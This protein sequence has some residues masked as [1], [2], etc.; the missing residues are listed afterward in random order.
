MPPKAK[1]AQPSKKTVEKKKEKVIEDKTFGLKNKK[2]AK[3]QKFI[4]QVQHQV[5]N[6]GAAKKNDELKKQEKEKKLK[7]QK[8]MN[9]LFKPVSTQKVEKGIDPKS[10]LCAFFKQGQCTKGDKCKFSHDLSLERKAEK[11]S[12][13]VDMRDDEDTMENWDEEK[14]KEVVEK[15]HGEQE[16]K[17]PPTDIICKYFIDAL[18]KSKYGW[19]WQCP[20]GTGCIY[21]HALPPGFVLKKDKKKEDKKDEISLEDLI[22]RERA[23]LGATLTKIT[24]QTFTTWKKRKLKEKKEAALKE[25]EKKRIDFKAGR[26]I[27]MS[28]REMFYFNPELAAADQCEEGDEA[29][30]SYNLQ[31]EDEQRN[32][33][34]REIRLDFLE[35]EAQ[36]VDGTG[37]QAKED[38]LKQAAAEHISTNGYV[39]E[40]DSEASAVPINESL[41]LDDD[42]DLEALEAELN[43]LEMEH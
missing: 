13:Y 7:E 30:D 16:R 35:L 24:L 12:M 11:R 19:F 20:N 22:E 10:V 25:E 29:F 40:G 26:Q 36:E 1:P 2:G 42:E 43:A 9:M 21:R 39:N 8:E 37:T 41:F 15:K 28:G 32:I 6:A 31:E 17:M 38:R 14:L 5:K 27:G 18:E 3:Q 23:A 33:E 34:Y 4:Q